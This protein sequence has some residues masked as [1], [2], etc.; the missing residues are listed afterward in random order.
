LSRVFSV[1]SEQSYLKAM[2]SIC[3]W[4]KKQPKNGASHYYSLIK[5]IASQSFQKESETWVPKLV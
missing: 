4:S 1:D 5:G 3:V 2:I